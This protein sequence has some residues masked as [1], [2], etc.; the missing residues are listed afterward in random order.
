MSVCSLCAASSCQQSDHCRLPPALLFLRSA[1]LMQKQPPGL[2]TR[3]AV[4]VLSGWRGRRTRKGAALP[5]PSRAGEG[6]GERGRS[7]RSLSYPPPVL[8]QQGAAAAGGCCRL[9][10]TAARPVLLQQGAAAAGRSAAGSSC[11]YPLPYLRRRAAAVAYNACYT[12]ASDNRAPIAYNTSIICPIAAAA[13]VGDTTAAAAAGSLPPAQRGVQGGARPLALSG[14]C[15]CI[16]AV[17]ERVERRQ[18]CQLPLAGAAAATWG[19]EARTPA[20]AGER[21][22][23]HAAA[24]VRRGRRP[25]G[26]ALAAAARRTPRGWGAGAASANGGAV[27][28]QKG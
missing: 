25:S 2:V 26:N 24:C 15:C 10:L 22:R 6:R 11:C 17:P 14:S 20:G 28:T 12:S 16:A 5:L 9:P 7:G 19:H 21:A 13:A 23:A 1:S 18:R 3:T 27:G 8:P 4:F